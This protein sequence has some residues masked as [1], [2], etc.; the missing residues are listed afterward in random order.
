MRRWVFLALLVSPVR[1]QAAGTEV[2]YFTPP[3]PLPAQTK[4]GYCWVHSI[5]AWA[6]EDAFRC[7]AGNTIYDPCFATDKPDRVLCDVKPA[8]GAAGFQLKL[9]RPL[10][11]MD[12]PPAPAKPSPWLIQLADGSY[13]S[14]F[15]GTLPQVNGEPARYGCQ[16]GK[17]EQILLVGELNRGAKTWT[18]RKAVMN[19]SEVKSEQTVAIRR[20]WE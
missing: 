4:S 15:T 14:A 11:P 3:K 19:G 1:A 10:P 18:A 12:N 13:C 16:G 5:A 2:I 8:T 20:V 9:T 7:M 17:T 6:R